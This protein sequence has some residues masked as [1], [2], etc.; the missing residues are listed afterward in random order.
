VSCI[1]DVPSV[2]TLVDLLPKV[3]CGHVVEASTVALASRGVSLG[4]RSCNLLVASWSGRLLYFLLNVAA[5]RLLGV[6]VAMV[7]L[8]VQ[9]VV[10]PSRV[11]SAS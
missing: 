5:S 10:N 4:L 3:G 8:V 2:M 7:V 6:L 9:V 11:G 1:D